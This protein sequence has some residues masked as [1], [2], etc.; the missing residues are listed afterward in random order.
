MAFGLSTL[1]AAPPAHADE[2][3]LIIEP[4][5]NSLS[6]IDPT[7]GADLS[8]VLGDLTRASPAA[9]PDMAIPIHRPKHPNPLFQSTFPSQSD[10]AQPY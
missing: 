2:F 5:I 9:H 7:L 10:C 1:A 3:E 6:S 4:I 8:A